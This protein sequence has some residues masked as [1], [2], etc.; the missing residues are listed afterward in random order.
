M[1]EP[2]CSCLKLPIENTNFASSIL[3]VD[4]T[5]GR[6]ADVTVEQCKLCNRKWLR[7][8]VEYESFTKSGRWYRGIV[9]DNDLLEITPE[10][11]IAY[12]EKLDWYI[13]GGS[14]FSSTGAIGKGKAL[15]DL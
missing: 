2:D 5:N 10:N 4:N 7:Y 1:T 3:G 11:S 12:I 8:F 14:Y 6:Y 9:S 13:Y 15:V